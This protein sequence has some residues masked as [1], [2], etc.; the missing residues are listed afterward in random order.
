[1]GTKFIARSVKD[2]AKF[3]LDKVKPINHVDKAFVPILFGHANEDDFIL[4]SHSEE[5]HEKY[6]GDKNLITFDGDHNTPRPQFF[7][8]SVVI[9]FINS[10]QRNFLVPQE[11]RE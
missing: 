1:M 2:K 6:A 7:E 9:F 8:D 5:L 3:E 4:P 11:K 10:L